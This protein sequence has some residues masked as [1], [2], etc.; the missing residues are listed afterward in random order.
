MRKVLRFFLKQHRSFK[1]YVR[2]LASNKEYFVA[3]QKLIV[4]SDYRQLEEMMLLGL[5]VEARIFN[6]KDKQHVHA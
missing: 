3:L 2:S 5:N 6:G 1:A 4:L